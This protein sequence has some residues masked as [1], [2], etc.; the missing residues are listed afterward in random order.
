M[1]LTKPAD[2]RRVSPPTVSR[3]ADG[4]LKWR[5]K[6]WQKVHWFVGVVLYVRINSSYE[7]S[8]IGLPSVHLD[9]LSLCERR[10]HGCSYCWFA[11]VDESN[12]NINWEAVGVGRSELSSA[13]WNDDVHY[14]VRCQLGWRL[15]IGSCVCCLFPVH[16]LFFGYSLWKQ[17]RHFK[18]CCRCFQDCLADRHRIGTAAAATTAG[19]NEIRHLEYS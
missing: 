7:A 15:L 3:P 17:R 13:N 4:C 8:I 16:G 2:V 9:V 18:H 5:T 11:V 6:P 12:K 10:V 14:C 1:L 19:N